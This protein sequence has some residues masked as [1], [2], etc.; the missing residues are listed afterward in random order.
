MGEFFAVDI[1]DISNPFKFG[2]LSEVYDAQRG[3]SE[4]RFTRVAVVKSRSHFVW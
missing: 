2:S 3:G 1:A 4:L